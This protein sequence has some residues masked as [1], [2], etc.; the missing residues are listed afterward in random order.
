MRKI[1]GFLMMIL[2]SASLSGCGSDMPGLPV[3][4]QDNVVGNTNLNIMNRGL[5]AEQGNKVYFSDSGKLCS[6]NRDG[7]NKKELT[8]CFIFPC[9][10]VIGDWIYFFDTQG[11]YEEGTIEYGIY[12][13]KTNGNERTKIVS[14]YYVSFIVQNNMIYYFD[15]EGLNQID[16]NG[17][18]G[19]ILF[20]K[21]N[22]YIDP[23]ECKVFLFDGG[24]RLFIDGGYGEEECYTMNLD[25]TDVKT[26]RE[27]FPEFEWDGSEWHDRTGVRICPISDELFCV[28]D[29]REYNI[30]DREGNHVHSHYQDWPEVYTYCEGYLLANDWNKRGGNSLFLEGKEFIDLELEYGVDD[31]SGI[32]IAGD[33]LYIGT[34]K[35]IGEK[36]DGVIC[37]LAILPM[38]RVREFIG[39]WD[40]K[41]WK[42]Y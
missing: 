34:E 16:V 11:S 33:S 24:L 18:N 25:G 35:N 38:K 36:G 13:V 7:S 29:D 8:E 32:C 9:I 1:Q 17:E 42:L 10:N 41:E 5:A 4:V 21:E 27:E 40:E 37:D 14:T 15:E 19:Q 28:T 20:S 26:L 22:S 6:A 12:K 23:Q 30:I 39:N 2:L 31:V 3:G